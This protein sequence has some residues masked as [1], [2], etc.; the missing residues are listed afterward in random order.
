LL[1]K[2]PYK[3]AT[4][5]EIVKDFSHCSTNEDLKPV[6]SDFLFFSIFKEKY[7]FFLIGKVSLLFCFMSLTFKI[8]C[9][10]ALSHSA[11]GF[12]YLHVNTSVDK[13]SLHP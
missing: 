5:P 11:V 4:V 1:W 3:V 2:G 12:E 6:L 7:I 10:L 8:W 13:H 9:T